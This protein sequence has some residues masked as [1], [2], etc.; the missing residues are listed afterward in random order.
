MNEADAAFQYVITQVIN[1][2]YGD[3]VVPTLQTEI[4]IYLC[5][6]FFLE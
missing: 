5:R 2:T 4:Q 3:I 1:A 6:L